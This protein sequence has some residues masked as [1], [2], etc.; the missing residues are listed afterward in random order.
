[1]L[2]TGMHVHTDG[3]AFEGR[4]RSL[5]VAG[6]A[7]VVTDGEGVVLSCIWG[8]VPLAEAPF[9]AARD[10]EDYAVLQL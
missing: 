4:F 6:W 10:G 5:G 3:S 1:M 8:V 9:Q 7:V 2:G